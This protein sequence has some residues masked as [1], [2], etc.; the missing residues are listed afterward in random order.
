MISYI[1][2]SSLIA[3]LLWILFGPVSLFLNT[4]NN[5]YYL[6]LP[7]IFKVMVVPSP[8]I[9][10]LRVWILFIPFRLNPFQQKK[11]KRK[12]KTKEPDKRK[13]TFRFRGGPQIIIDAFR[14][15]RIRKLQMD[16]DTDDFIL[17]AWLV[18][19]FSMVNSGNIQMKVNFQG[20]SSLLFDVRTRLG[21]LLWIVIKNKYRSFINL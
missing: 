6:V 12:K 20:H 18:P 3:F 8:D 11:E 2:I 4:E 9:F 16:I 7:G 14:S 5:R 13:K 15:M 21:T 10:R 17:N 1:I 19:V